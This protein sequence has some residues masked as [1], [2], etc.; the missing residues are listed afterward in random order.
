MLVRVRRKVSGECARARV[1]ALP[2]QEVDRGGIKL[3]RTSMGKDME[4]RKSLL[5]VSDIVVLEE[6]LARAYAR[7]R[8]AM[9]T[10][11]SDRVSVVEVVELRKM[12][13]ELS[14]SVVWMRRSS[15]K[16]RIAERAE[17]ISGLLFLE[18]AM[19]SSLFLLWVCW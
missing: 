15:R 9:R 6:Y 2:S 4:V 19:L 13:R 3:L 8:M 7:Q 11:R 5:W 16:K 1:E 12:R 18:T 17:G 14:I 10:S